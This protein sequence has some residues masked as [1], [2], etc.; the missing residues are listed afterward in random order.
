M[1]RQHQPRLALLW[2]VIL[3]AAS[4]AAEPNAP[5]SEQTK[6]AESPSETVQKKSDWTISTHVV[7]RGQHI[8]LDGN[9]ILERDGVLE[10]DDCTLEIVGRASREHLV[11]WR[12][13][14]LITRNTV[15]GGAVRDGVPIHTVFHVY[16][17]Q[18][19]AYDTTIQYAYGVSFHAE[20]RGV[21]RGERVRAGPRPDAIIASGKADITLVDSTFPMALGIYTNA[22]GKTTLDLPVGKPVDAVY[23]GANL[24]GVEYRLSLTRHVVP[25]QWFVFL[26]RITMHRPPCEIVLRD[27]PRVLAS[28]L[29]WNVQGELRLSNTLEQPLRIGNV[30]L[31]KADRPV[32]ISMW[33]I[34]FGGDET[35]LT[36]HG[37]TRVAELMHRGGKMR[38][39]GTPGEHDLVL[40]C[41]TLE[42]S[43]NAKMSLENVHLGRPLSWTSV[44]AMGEVNVEGDAVLTGKNVSVNRVV[45]HTRDNGQI[46]LHGVMEEGRIVSRQEGGSIRVNRQ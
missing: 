30:T 6:K 43:G 42:M 27:C 31:R 44:K 38:F 20:T 18:W 15:I 8:V 4:V 7:V 46:D 3:V 33:S 25:Y 9:L 22:G 29:G 19:E 12:G 28:V 41:T 14:R 21:L 11:D 40:G 23:D 17:G 37:P 39:I 34:Y 2:N 13:G 45:L 5:P 32:A 24:P 16:D 10:L 36:V 26:R 35:D 1:R